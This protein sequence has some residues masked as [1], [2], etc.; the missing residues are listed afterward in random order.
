MN[1]ELTTFTL[2]VGGW[3]GAMYSASLLTDGL[4]LNYEKVARVLSGPLVGGLL[5]HLAVFGLYSVRMSI[6]YV[7]ISMLSAV[8]LTLF[9][10]SLVVYVFAVLGFRAFFEMQVKT[11]AQLAADEI[12]A[13]EAAAA[14]AVPAEEDQEHNP[15]PDSESEDN[16]TIAS[17]ATE[18]SEAEATQA[19]PDA[20][21][22]ATP[23]FPT[24]D[25]SSPD[26]D[27]YHHMLTSWSSDSERSSPVAT[28]AQQQSES[29]SDA[30]ESKNADELTSA[31]LQ[32]TSEHVTTFVETH[33]RTSS[34]GFN[35][36][37]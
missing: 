22:Q 6:G 25:R 18:E 28:V 36:S 1:S 4:P 16:E 37:L 35:D 15:L 31:P 2:G 7:Y 8:P 3:M 13:D 10:A 24:H 12:A 33:A 23:D 17:E 9:A 19:A 30:T 26:S 21:S 32:S 14:A 11:A 34:V 20:V 29:T 5:A 27:G